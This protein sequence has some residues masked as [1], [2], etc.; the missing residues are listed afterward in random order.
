M[1]RSG[2]V[3]LEEIHIQRVLLCHLN[4]DI[5]FQCS[6]QLPNYASNSKRGCI[7][8]LQHATKTYHEVVLIRPTQSLISRA[9]KAFKMG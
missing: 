9:V 6:Y 7:C 8:R 3:I 1:S 4:K 5:G 2:R